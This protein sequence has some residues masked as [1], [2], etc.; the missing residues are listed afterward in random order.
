MIKNILKGVG[1]F[2]AV[3]LIIV[4]LAIT[5]TIKYSAINNVTEMIILESNAKNKGLNMPFPNSFTFKGEERELTKVFE[6]ELNEFYVQVL[7][8]YDY[9]INEYD[10]KYWSYVWL[11]W[12]KYHKEEWD[13]DIVTTTNHVFVILYNDE[14]YCVA[15]Q[16]LL[17]CVKVN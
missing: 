8:N 14:K 3:F 15:D 10:C 16:D 17:N 6:K 7:K 9:S 13:F 1:V 12:W 11:H 4:I 2:F 5:L